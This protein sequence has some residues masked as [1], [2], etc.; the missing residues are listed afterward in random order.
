MAALAAAL[1]MI[2]T[3]CKKNI[4]PAAK[5]P[6]TPKPAPVEAP[7]AKPVI[8]FNA[9]PSSIVRGDAVTLRWTVQ[10][11]DAVT[12]E[13]G[14]GTVAASG[15][16]QV[17]PTTAT[18][19]ILRA[20]GPGGSDSAR[21]SVSVSAPTEKPPAAP[22][23]TT[24]DVTGALE[25]LVKDAYFGYDSA[26]IREDARATLQRNSDGLKEIF[27]KFSSSNVIVEGH[28]DE[29]GSAEYNLGLG[30][31]RA[32]AA[33]EFLVQLGVPGDKL[34]S[35]TYGKERQTCTDATEDCWQKNRRA[36]FALGQ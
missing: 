13:P 28:C 1:M 2:A 31:K 34:K 32:N 26:E 18:T 29:R 5:L 16:R 33:R 15:S 9:D 4:P 35:V 19:Y 25:R 36:H 10:N 3:G 12:I 20:S 30:E 22:S 6:D 27:G 17:Y 11:A 8:S 24:E 14:V 23:G 21:V 7:K